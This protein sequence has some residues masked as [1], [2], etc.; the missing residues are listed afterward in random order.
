MALY[1][2]PEVTMRELRARIIFGKGVRKFRILFGWTQA[3]LAKRAGISR[4]Y[5]QRIESKNP[6]DISIDIIGKLAR[7]FRNP[8]WK[9]LLP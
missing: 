6:P 5:L 8:P 9:L 3:D 2:L 7:A 1:V 4:S